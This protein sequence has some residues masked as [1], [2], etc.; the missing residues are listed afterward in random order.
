MR[1]LMY[2]QLVAFCAG[3]LLLSIALRSAHAHDYW[4]N[5]KRVDPV[6]KNLCCDGGDTKELDPHTVIEEQGGFRLL[7]TGEFI[8]FDR[9]QPS[10]DNSIWA[11]RWGFPRPST[12]C[13]FYPSGS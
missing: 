13:F 10:P 9:V 8:P 1:V 7:D 11:S 4:S 3:C 6:T 2:A 12:Q 5:G